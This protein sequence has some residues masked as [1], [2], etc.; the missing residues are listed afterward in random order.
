[1][2]NLKT[3]LFFRTIS[4]FPQ[5]DELNLDDHNITLQQSLIEHPLQLSS[6]QTTNLIAIPTP[7]STPITIQESPI[8]LQVTSPT[9]AMHALQQLS[10]DTITVQQQQ[11]AIHLPT[12][13][14]LSLIQPVATTN[15]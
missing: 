3:F 2:I 1:M 12:I 6:A 14:V 15:K 4:T 9:S 8:T 7:T 5:I 10:N 13:H 11:S